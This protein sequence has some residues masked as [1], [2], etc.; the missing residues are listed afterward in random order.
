MRVPRIACV[1]VPDFALAW[2]LARHPE[3]AATPVVL[4]EGRQAGA[5]VVAVN[6]VAR[7]YDV[8]PGLSVSQARA[9]AKALHVQVRDLEAER[10]LSRRVVARLQTVTPAVEEESPGLWFLESLGQGRLYGGERNF[11]RRVFHTLDALALPVCV[12]LAGNRAVARVA[13]QVSSPR[14]FMIIPAGRERKFLAALPSHHVAA[15]ALQPYLRVLGLDTIHQV[16]E[17]PASQWTA[18]F[19]ESG[20]ELQKLARGLEGSPFA[21]EALSEPRR[22]AEAF[23]FPLFCSV[24]LVQRAEALLAP[25]LAAL[26]SRQQAAHAV[27]V[28]FDLED[29]SKSSWVLAL[30]QPTCATAPF[31]RQFAHRLTEQAPCAG[32]R[33]IV[34]QI[35]ASAAAPVEQLEWSHPP[36]RVVPRELP[37]RSGEWRTPRAL[38]AALPEAA[39]EWRAVDGKTPRATLPLSGEP[40]IDIPCL[41]SA[42]G[43]RLFSPAQRITAVWSEGVLT[44]LEGPGLRERVQATRGPWVVSGHWWRQPFHRLYYEVDTA[45]G[46][47]LVYY[48]R[49]AGHWYAQGLFD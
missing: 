20:A 47:Y 40:E 43:L 36:A 11:I 41:S 1:H 2:W 22:Q 46:R 19:G 15:P 34:V 38:S 37:T 18:R 26:A 13:A 8:R 28:E 35:E 25:L 23:E 45:G 42:F 32:V 33:G 3:S 44:T 5:P 4:A 17:L 9:C 49:A 30:A 10:D 39:A 27:R 24:T 12:G 31:A 14:S 21:P 6:A 29:G 7:A 16:A 48:D